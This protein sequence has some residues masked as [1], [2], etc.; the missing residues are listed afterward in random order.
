LIAFPSAPSVCFTACRLFDITKPLMAAPPMV[1]ISN[2]T[3]SIS[4]SMLPPAVT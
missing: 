3:A 4:G 1:H 2:G